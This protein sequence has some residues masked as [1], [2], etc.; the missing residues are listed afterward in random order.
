MSLPEIVSR[1]EWHAAREELLVKEKV[2]TRAR[3]ALNAER[4]R[5][6]MVEITEE[7]VFDGGDG[8]ASLLDLFDARHQLVVYHFMFAP[9]WEAALPQ[10]LGLPRPDRPPRPSEG[11]R[12][13]V[14]RGLAG[15]LPEDPAV[16]GTHGL[17]AALVLLVRQRLQPGLRCH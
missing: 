10:L 4:R 5:L 6:P 15:T 11:A 8:K 12:H 1:E 3:D 14:R 13:V 17:G 16:Q 2:V 9:E 7:Y